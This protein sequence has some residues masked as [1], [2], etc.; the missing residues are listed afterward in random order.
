MLR[1]TNVELLGGYRLR[2]SF[3]GGVVRDVDCS[4]LLYGTLGQPL[5]EPDYFAQVT[6]DHE[7]RTIIWP[8]GLD[9]APELLHGGAPAEASLGRASRAAA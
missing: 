2:I 3:T 5:R 1:V 4:F 8:N 9:P 7:A 6:V